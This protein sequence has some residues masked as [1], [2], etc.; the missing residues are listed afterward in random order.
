MQKSTFFWITSLNSEN[1][2]RHHR[3]HLEIDSVELIEARPGT[4][5]GKT[6]EELAQGN[7]IETIGAV[8]HNALLGDGFG[9]ILGRLGFAGT[10]M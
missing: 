5:R 3:Q 6:L 1:L 8:E 7:V 4:A 10:Y 9:Q 2:L